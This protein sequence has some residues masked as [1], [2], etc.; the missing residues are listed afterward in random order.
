MSLKLK[1]NTFVNVGT[2]ISAPESVDIE[3][4]GNRAFNTNKMIEIRKDKKVLRWFEKPFGIL[5]LTV[6]GGVIVGGIL[7][8]F[9]WN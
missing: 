8:Y 9:N 3:A 4:E 1:N 7:F 5:S 6:I 2:G